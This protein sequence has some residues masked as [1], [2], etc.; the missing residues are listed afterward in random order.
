MLTATI[1]ERIGEAQR[2]RLLC[3]EAC[4]ICGLTARAVW[5]DGDVLYGRC[6]RTGLVYWR[7]NEPA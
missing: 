1:G 7:R 5:R 3:L 4:P 2:L 6:V